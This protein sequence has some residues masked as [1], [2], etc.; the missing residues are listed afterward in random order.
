MPVHSASSS[1]AHPRLSVQTLLVA[2]EKL[3]AAWDSRAD[4]S[5]TVW[6]ISQ[7]AV[8][9][10]VQLIRRTRPKGIVFEEAFLLT[11]LGAELARVLRT[12]PLLSGLEIRTLS[13]ERVTA[14][15]SGSAPIIPDALTNLARVVT[16]RRRTVRHQ[17]PEG[18]Q[19]EVNGQPMNL[20]D[21]S[22]YG[23]QFSGFERLRPRGRV[24]VILSSDPTTEIDGRVVW[25]EMFGAGTCPQYRA[26]VEFSGQPGQQV[27]V[28]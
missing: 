5:G 23:V 2:S 1:T 21:Y 18:T 25:S 27:Q 6:T 9:T 10:V 8:K 24:R 12:D 11:H 13:P 15:C 4:H 14:L 26:G 19:L 7:K 22:V 28:S 3:V 17:A 20:V 16:S